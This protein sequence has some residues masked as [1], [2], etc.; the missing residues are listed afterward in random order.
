M[1]KLRLFAGSLLLA[2]ALFGCIK[3]E[4]A[5]GVKALREAQAAL[6]NAKAANETTLANAEAAFVQAQA[7]IEEAKALQAAAQ[8][9][10]QELQND[11]REAQNTD[12]IARMEA[13]LELFQVQKQGEIAAAQLEAE[14]LLNNAKIALEGSIRALKA[15]IAISE[16]STPALDEYLAKYTE[17]VAKV[18]GLQGQIIG[19]EAEIATAEYYNSSNDLM[20][21]KLIEKEKLN[22]EK[23]SLEA[24]K[25]RY[26]AVSGGRITVAEAVL[27]AREMEDSLEFAREEV[28]VERA[29][30]DMLR[31]NASTIYTNAN[32]DYQEANNALAKIEQFTNGIGG[33]IPYSFLEV[34]YDVPNPTP[35][36]N[37]FQ[38]ADYYETAIEAME[39]GLSNYELV[40]EE[41]LEIKDIYA[42]QIEDLEAAIEAA[43]EE[44]VEKEHAYTL[45]V[46][47]YQADQ[48]TAKESAMDNAETEL[49]DAQD[50]LTDAIVDYANF[51]NDINDSDLTD[52]EA[53]YTVHYNNWVDGDLIFTIDDLIAWYEA[54]I[55][56]REAELE[57]YEL[58]L[59]VVEAYIAYLESIDVDRIPELKEAYFAARAAYWAAV[60]KYNELNSQEI[61]LTTE[62]SR[63][64]I[65]V[66]ALENEEELINDNLD[67]IEKG[68]YQ[69]EAAVAMIDKDFASWEAYK[70]KLQRELTVLEDE[71]AV[72]QKKAENYYAL[73]NAELDGTNEETEQ[74]ETETETAE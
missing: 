15:E 38:A 7:K 62:L 6:I 52:V 70:T 25:T 19:K 12:D 41:I 20:N 17:A 27:D 13:D 54:R 46:V 9:R 28:R 43:R 71:L 48:T 11:L 59:A 14:V 58:D 2:G 3:N 69:T 30:Q 16:V 67:N 4:E 50:A 8:A 56:Q 66:N 44:V 33:S 21:L 40:Y 42:D 36:F 49:Q 35:S 39:E 60:E 63:T 31:A 34:H 74:T 1:K 10:Y 55:A 5:D 53:H 37:N 65:Y 45:A 32:T 47:E 23:A 72:Y 29:K 51:R 18:T 73:V 22:N 24:W 57:D 61:F 64:A 26:E 68:I